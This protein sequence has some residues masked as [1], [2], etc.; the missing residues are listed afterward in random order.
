M[1]VVVVVVVVVAVVLVVVVVTLTLALQD[2]KGACSYFENSYLLNPKPAT[3]ISTANMHLKMG[4]VAVV[5]EVCAP[6]HPHHI[7]NDDLFIIYVRSRLDLGA[8]R[9][10]VYTRVLSGAAGELSQRE[11]EVALRKLATC[12]T[13]L[14]ATPEV[15]IQPN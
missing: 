12:E 4:H 2:Y 8:R 9:V 11:R 1:V 10:Q 3:L 15:E 14:G 13:M 6:P 5:S 7:N